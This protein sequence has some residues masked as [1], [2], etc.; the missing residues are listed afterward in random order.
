MTVPAA[1]AP[2]ASAP[3]SPASSSG[4]RRV[5]SWS[6][7]PWPVS[8]CSPKASPW[9]ATA[10]TSFRRPAGPAG[11]QAA[12]LAVDGGH[13]GGVGRRVGG[14][15]I[16]EMDPHE[17]RTV[18]RRGRQEGERG[19]DHLGGRPFGVA[20]F[21]HPFGGHGVVVELEAAAEPEAGVEHPRGG[22]G[23]G[24]IA[25]AAQRFGE[26]RMARVEAAPAVVAQAVAGRFE[27]RKQRGVR[28]QGERHRRIGAGEAHADGG[29]S[30]QVGCRRR[31]NIRG[32]RPGWCRG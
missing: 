18:A 20:V 27:T 13:F 14:V 11:Q 9:S 15:R 22:K 30:I 24:V 12:E 2:A 19:V 32:R 25:G 7:R 17:K 10:A 26:Q 8:P 1:S 29:Q 16:V 31:R 23:G 3:E 4:T 28:R 5:G 6:S 21:A